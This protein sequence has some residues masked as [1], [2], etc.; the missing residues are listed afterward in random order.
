[1]GA[2]IP[3][4]A[5]A[6]F[7]DSDEHVEFTVKNQFQME[8][9]MGLN[10]FRN[11]NVF[12]NF[13]VNDAI[14]NR[15]ISAAGLIGTKYFDFTIDFFTYNGTLEYSPEFGDSWGPEAH[16]M[17]NRSY[18]LMFSRLNI[19]SFGFVWNVY[20]FPM[21]IDDEFHPSYDINAYGFRIKLHFNE[22]SGL[23]LAP[24]PGEWEGTQFGSIMY[25]FTFSEYGT[26][27]L[28]L[29]F[30]YGGQAA[31]GLKNGTYLTGRAS[32]GFDVNQ[33]GV[34]PGLF[35]RVGYAF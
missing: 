20:S 6:V 13:G 21:V 1:M 27:P 19:L 22:N 24:I 33:M 30:L 2:A 18:A 34:L 4:D 8:L 32:V 3:I 35:L 25:E 12:F 9:S 17:T 29:Q 26:W 7:I 28:R 15:A 31:Y 16:T 23:D 10:V 11:I 14:F 5:G